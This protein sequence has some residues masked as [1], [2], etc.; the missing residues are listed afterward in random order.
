MLY[1]M[2]VL[3]HHGCPAYWYARPAY[4]H[5]PGTEEVPMSEI[6]MEMLT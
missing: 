1:D 2:R 4:G 3:V 6:D 5:W